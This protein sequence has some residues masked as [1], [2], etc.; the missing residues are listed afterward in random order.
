M[1]A[2]DNRTLP[3]RADAA[4]VAQDAPW[5][6]CEG[7][8]PGG[9]LELL[10]APGTALGFDGR[11]YA[12]PPPAAP[13]V[14]PSLGTLRDVSPGT[15]DPAAVAAGAGPP[16][17]LRLDLAEWDAIEQLTLWGR[18]RVAGALATRS[19]TMTP[20]RAAAIE[21]GEQ[22]AG[23]TQDNLGKCCH[24]TRIGAASP[25]LYRTPRGKLVWSG[26]VRCGDRC[27]PVCGPAY[28]QKSSHRTGALIDRWLASD[29]GG[30]LDPDAWM[31]TLAPPHAMTDAIAASVDD[32]YRI[33]QLFMRTPEWRAF[34]LRWQLARRDERGRYQP[35]AGVVPYLDASFG[36]ANGAHVH[37]HTLLLVG[38]ARV[39]GEQRRACALRATAGR[40]PDADDVEA[41]I[42]WEHRAQ[43]IA[44]DYARAVDPSSR[45]LDAPMRALDQH[46]RCMLLDRF[47][48][49]AGL[50]V[51]LTRVIQSVKPMQLER[52]RRPSIFATDDEAAAAKRAAARAAELAQYTSLEQ[53][54]PPREDRNAPREVPCHVAPSALQLTPGEDAARYFTAWGLESELGASPLKGRSHL[55][56]LDAAGAGVAFAGA[57]WQQWREAVRG[58]RWARGLGAALRRLGLDD[59]AVSA[60]AAAKQAERDELRA[61]RERR[62]AERERRPVE[63]PP[64]LAPL[65]VVV[66][67]YLWGAAH[68]AGLEVVEQLAVAVA[69]AGGDAQQ[70]V[71]DLCW[72][73]Q[74]EA[75]A[76]ARARG[77]P[78][79]PS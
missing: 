30:L 6:P 59:A 44:D 71:I 40:R 42:A 28:A 79:P 41:L 50:L 24:G 18:R 15:P 68:V 61:E 22:L 7:L 78:P 39:T 12:A 4:Q 5:R 8:A 9:Q 13:A 67:W 53:P 33:E 56:L 17:Q 14:G 48:A 20:A 57:T 58:R 34:A 2:P 35:L 16:G 37:F 54:P 27:C 51:A 25:A 52:F 65:S 76:R 73:Y 64:V 38:G 3:P 29:A 19:G 63:L 31:L 69:D 72:R 66:P 47:A 21:A 23:G 43:R 45:W 11:G 26:L 36:G 10:E 60:W 32:L 46:E 70:A 49:D 77:R 75:N 55:R 1:E 74:S 62:A